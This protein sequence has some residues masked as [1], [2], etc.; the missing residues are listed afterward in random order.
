MQ[1]FKL[2][3]ALILV[4]A[5]AGGLYYFSFLRNGKRELG[6]IHVE[7]LGD[8][9]LFISREDVSKLLILKN[10][11]ASNVTKEVLD[12]NKLESVLNSNA[13]IED[14][15]VSVSVTGELSAKV[16]QKKPIARVITNT[17]YYIDRN[18]KFMPLSD[19]YAERVPI[20]TGYVYKDEL[21]VVYT[22]ATKVLEDPFLKKN[23]VEIYQNKDRTIFLKLR[24]CDFKVHLG[25]LEELD[26]K[27]NNLKAFYIK[28]RRDKL[29]KKYSK[30][31][32]QF[33]NQ[34]VCTKV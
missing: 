17:S 4:L 19:T 12:L 6:K 15:Q 28:A 11:N 9:N 24:Q 18:G 27:I 20:V 2:Y 23:V 32:L 16:K 22:M 21:D 14:A 8:K 34:V 29:I 3:I 10:G 5:S 1:K 7:F 33:D 25:S 26:K 30:V 31:N 13:I